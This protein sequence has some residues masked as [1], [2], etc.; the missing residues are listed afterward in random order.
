MKRQTIFSAIICVATSPISFVEATIGAKTASNINMDHTKHS[1]AWNIGGK[2]LFD[3]TNKAYPIEDGKV[4]VNLCR[5]DVLCPTGLGHLASGRTSV[6]KSISL[7]FEMKLSGYYWLHILWNPGGSGNEQF[8][9]SCNGISVGKSSL[10][11]AK[12]KPNQQLAEKFKVKLKK[13]E[14]NIR[15]Q[16]LSGDGLHF[17]NII[18]HTSEKI[19]LF[20]PPLKLNLKYP[21]L[22]AYEAAIEEPGVMLDSTYVRLFAPKLRTKEA[23]T[24]FEYLVK[25]YE[26]LY[27]L[28]G[29]YTEYKM[30][31]Y[32]FPQNHPD[33]FGGTSSC[34]IWYGYEN[35]ELE[36]D[37]EWKQ[38]GVPHV[39]GYIEEMAHNFVHASGAHFGWE[40]IGW[41]ISTKITTKVADNPIQKK[42]C[43][44]PEK[45]RWK[46][47]NGTLSRVMFSPRIFQ[48]INV[49]GYTP[50]Y[51]FYA[52]KN[53][54]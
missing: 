51:C 54:D 40:M 30:V 2:G 27:Q 46:P 53:T 38:Y 1:I 20:P 39:C 37:K 3:G 33:I 45:S 41:T 34:T 18:L 42:G 21:T 31:V 48:E 36:H 26:E 50:I 5:E 44:G 52:R 35:L 6:V 17:K 49:T 13:G 7:L 10:V 14:N 47:S 43:R 16:H 19:G 24:I 23:K 25:A 4:T 9:I 11:H 22:R 8:E 15:L 32:H 28:T 29:V 12:Q